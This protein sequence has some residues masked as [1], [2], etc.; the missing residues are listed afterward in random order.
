M[1]LR[2]VAKYY[3]LFNACSV[4]RIVNRIPTDHN[5]GLYLIYTDLIYCL[6][7]ATKAL[8]TPMSCQTYEFNLQRTYSKT[9]VLG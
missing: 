5:K 6:K 1:T 2:L 8:Y 9:L 3:V 7:Y 4:I